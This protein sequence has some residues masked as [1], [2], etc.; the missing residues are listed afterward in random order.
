MVGEEGRVLLHVEAGGVGDVVALRLQPADHRRVAGEEPG[1]AGAGVGPQERDLGGPGRPRRR[2][3]GARRVV[4]VEALAAPRVVGLV[5]REGDLVQDRRVAA[6]VAQHEQGVGGGRVRRAAR[7]AGGVRGQTGDVDPRGPA[8]VRLHVHRRGP[9]GLDEPRGGVGGRRRPGRGGDVAGAGDLGGAGAAV[10]ALAVDRDV[11]VADGGAD[12]EPDRRPHVDRRRAEVALDGG[13][14]RGRRRRHGV[15]AGAGAGGGGGTGGGGDRA[16]GVGRA[17]GPR[18]LL[19]AQGGRQVAAAGRLP[20]VGAGLA[21]LGDDAVGR[22][23][24]P[25]RR[26]PP[27]EVARTTRPATMSD[28]ARTAARDGGQ[29]AGGVRSVGDIGH[30]ERPIRSGT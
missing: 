28:A 7:A 9:V 16:A 17:A 10:P 24:R 4:V 13:G 14:R 12:R 21:V 5:G 19:G 22:G 20:R 29:V 26:P 25:P 3:G 30:V 11:D 1:A 27:A 2:D 8:A 15:G 18:L 6:V 23:G